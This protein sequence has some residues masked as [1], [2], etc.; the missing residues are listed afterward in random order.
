[1]KAYLL[2]QEQD[3][4]FGADLP[5]NHEDLIQDLELAT[6]LEAMALGDKFLHEVSARVVLASL[7]DPEAILHRQRVLADCIAEPEIIREMYA[8]AVGAL[9]DKR[10]IWG[11]GS[12]SPSLILSGAVRQLEAA[13]IRLK[14]LRKIADDHAETFRSPGFTT[15]FRTLQREL[16]DE[17][18][19]TISY[20]L[21][22]LRFRNGELISAELDRDNSGL[23]FVLRSSGSV[24]RSWK[25]RLGID[26]RS[27]YSF[28]IPPRDDAG[29]NALSDLTSRGINLVANA[30]AQSADHIWSYFTMLRGELGFYVSCLNLWNQ[31]AVKEVPISFPAPSSWSQRV[32]SFSGLRDICLALRTEKRV[33]GNDID[34]NGKSL[35]IITG[36]NSGG[37]STFLRSV[38]LA[39]LMMQCGMFVAAE[40]YSASVCGGVFTHFIREEDTTM[41]SGRLDEELSRMSS[42]AD[43]IRPHCVMLFNESF[44]ATNEREGSEI[45]RQVVRALLEAEI[46][47]FF[48][49][50]QFDF[51]NGFHS[52]RAE[53]T[54]FLRAER[55]SEGQPSYKLAVA[56]PLPT[57]FGE[58]VYYR[59]GGWMDSDDDHNSL[60]ASVRETSASHVDTSGRVRQAG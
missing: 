7:G 39:Q 20:H 51:A 4:N 26:P 2:Y 45:G 9:E 50:H 38:G 28:T 21:K 41:T 10:G 46:T 44:A 3:F 42:I 11:Y 49:T 56:E 58:D 14:Q 29:A 43:Q 59:L 53:S 30:A 13:V 54:L 15:L 36:A 52:Q 35:I 12:Q 55:Q 17:Y 31:L 57:S 60:S 48:V 19:Q 6:L 27:T 18:F 37:K 24:K 32:L 40:T 5:P 25:E 33:V 1:M 47:V 34:A 23:G 16:D 22:Q 8:I